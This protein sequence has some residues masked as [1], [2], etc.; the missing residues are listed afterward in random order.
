M[1]QCS[2][3]TSASVGPTDVCIK[4]EEKSGVTLG[5]ILNHLNLELGTLNH[6]K[7]ELL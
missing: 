7:L 5:G 3:L 1:L 4:K 6:L 2:A